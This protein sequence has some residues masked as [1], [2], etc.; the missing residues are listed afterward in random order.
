MAIWSSFSAAIKNVKIFLT[1]C[2]GILNAVF[3]I[4]LFVA[5]GYIIFFLEFTDHSALMTIV[6]KT[7][8][9][10]SFLLIM[11][12]HLMYIADVGKVPTLIAFCFFGIT[13]YLSINVKSQIPNASYIS[14]GMILFYVINIVTLPLSSF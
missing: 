6:W 1:F 11:V 8:I 4:A 10:I 5:M 9:C 13:W 7:I 2:S 3:I 12:P 14:Y